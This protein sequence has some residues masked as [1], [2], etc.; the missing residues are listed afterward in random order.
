MLAAIQAWLLV[1]EDPDGRRLRL[2]T[3]ATHSLEIK[4]D[5]GSSWLK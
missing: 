3:L 1:F 2:Y 4:P 5:E